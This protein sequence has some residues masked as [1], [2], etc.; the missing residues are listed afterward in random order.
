MPYRRRNRAYVLFTALAI[1]TFIYVSWGP[2]QTRNSEFFT[3]T[4][5][6]LQQKE[7]EKAA[8]VRDAESVGARLKA[9]E[10]EA[11]KSAKDKGERYLES[12]EGS[13]NEKGVAGRVKLNQ[14][15]PGE[16]KLQGVATVGGKPRDREAA[17]MQDETPEDHEVEVEMNAIL[18]KSPSMYPLVLDAYRY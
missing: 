14:Q 8:L 16:K 1:L 15:N 2:S 11:K 7:Y 10:E 3:K 17:K 4:Q 18:K 9:A 12:V 6:A 13:G 5:E